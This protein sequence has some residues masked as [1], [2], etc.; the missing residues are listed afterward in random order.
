MVHNDGL[1]QV[2]IAGFYCVATESHVE[3]HVFRV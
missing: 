3:L 1:T 2:F